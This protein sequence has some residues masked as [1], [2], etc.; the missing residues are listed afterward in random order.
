MAKLLFVFPYSIEPQLRRILASTPFPEE[1]EYRTLV[2]TYL[3]LDDYRQDWPCDALIARGYTA[4][5][6]AAGGRCTSPIHK[7]AFTSGDALRAVLRCRD[8]F[9][10]KTIA[11]VCHPTLSMAAETL[12]KISGTPIRVYPL[13]G[14]AYAKIHEVVERAAAD[15]CDAFVGGGTCHAVATARQFN[16]ILVES[17]DQTLREAIESAI[18]MAT[19]QRQER[20]K[21]EILRTVMD[22]SREGLLLI[23]LDGRVAVCNQFTVRTLGEGGDCAGA[24]FLALLPEFALPVER[25]RKTLSFVDDE[26]FSRGGK[27]YSASLLPLVV[28]ERLNAILVSFQDVGQIQEMESQIRHKLHAKGMSTRYRFADIVH[29][30]PRMRSIIETAKRFAAVDSNVLLEGETGT[31][32]EMFAQ[33]IHA[34]SRRA[35]QPFVAVN[36]TVLPEHLLESEL[37][38]YSPGAFTGASKTG[39]KGLFELAHGGTLFLDEVSEIP[40][41]FQGKLLRALQEREIRRI[42]DDKTL[43]VDVRIVAATNRDLLDM[44]ERGLFRKDLY[45]RLDILA[46]R[47]PPLHQ[48]REDIVPL[49]SGFLREFSLKFA[50]SLPPVSR[51]AGALLE[52]H[53]WTG[54]IRELR[55]IAERL[56]VLWDGGEEDATRVLERI[57]FRFPLSEAAMPQAEPFVEGEKRRILSALSG[58]RGREE[59][60]RS[61]GMSRS[62]LWRKM[63][64]YGL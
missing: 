42:G 24:D 60:A 47:L 19:I 61:L 30:N 55:N 44:A 23:G 62:T 50:R 14:V 54:N 31:G 45:F 15:G 17:D 9:H 2:R 48:R 3:D 59:A 26:I 37:F 40:P 49:F 10:P 4:D 20:E 58:S 27:T 35:R 1:V 13:A 5:A 43:P 16:S 53:A 18:R 36:C 51:E 25:V 38:G 33:S 52:N 6:L 8:C 28:D 29:N 64:E 22:N 57:L 7:L 46:I 12:G 21:V 41:S 56:V 39:K 34:H 32:K 63:K 11:V